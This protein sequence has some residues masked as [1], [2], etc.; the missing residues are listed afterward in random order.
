MVSFPSGHSQAKHAMPSLSME[1][2]V[3]RTAG[4]LV[5]LAGT[6]KMTSVGTELPAFL[7]TL[8]APSEVVMVAPVDQ[9]GSAGKGTKGVAIES[10]G[11]PSGRQRLDQP[12]EMM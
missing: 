7:R 10:N 6:S 1:A 11:P 8:N 2:E 3:S 12:A 5:S 4:W 9:S